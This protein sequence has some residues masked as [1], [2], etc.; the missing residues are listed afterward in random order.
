MYFGIFWNYR[1][2]HF[3]YYFHLFRCAVHV[4]VMTLQQIVQTAANL[5]PERRAVCFDECNNKIPATYTYKTVTTLATELTD[6]LKKNCN[7]T[8]NVVIGLYC[9]P[10]INLP[11][12]II[13]Y[14]CEMIFVTLLRGKLN[15]PAI[16]LPG[17]QNIFVGSSQNI[18]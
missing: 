2:I 4:L 14:G 6:F 3:N 8:E 5:Y 18:F 9:C 1:L 13:G 7:F 10:G 12:W 15:I 17:S 11:S 16:L